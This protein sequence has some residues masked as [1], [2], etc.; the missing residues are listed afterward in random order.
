[1]CRAR[2]S[3]RAGQRLICEAFGDE[4]K[5]AFKRKWGNLPPTGD[6]LVPRSEDDD[7]LRVGNHNIHGLSLGQAEAL[8]EIKSIVEL[9]FN[10]QGMNEINWPWTAWNKYGYEQEMESVVGPHQTLYSAAP[11][12]HDT[13]Y[14]PGGTLLTINGNNAGRYCKGGADR[15]G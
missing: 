12:A 3:H 9:G 10:V 8:K 11:A 14:Q 13:T 1:M 15:M 5:A 4:N 7:I 2:P 6:T